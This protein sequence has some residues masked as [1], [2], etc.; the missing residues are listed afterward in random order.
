MPLLM[1]GSHRTHPESHTDPVAENGTEMRSAETEIKSTAS[2]RGFG[3]EWEAYRGAQTKERR[4]Q[5][6]GR[7]R[8]Q[9]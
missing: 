1:A 6:A 8:R 4:A 7:W 9:R 3:G 5:K 2:G